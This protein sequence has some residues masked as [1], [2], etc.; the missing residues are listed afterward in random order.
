MSATIIIAAHN[1][2]A[3][4]NKTIESTIDSVANLDYNIV[5][6][7]DASSDDSIDLALQHFPWLEVARH[8]QRQGTSPTEA[9]GARKASGDVLVFLDG[10]TKPEGDA[11][12]V[13]N[14]QLWTNNLNQLGH[15][16]GMDLEMF[17]TQWKDVDELQVAKVGRMTFY[18]SPALIGCAF[19]VSRLLY[20]RLWG[21]DAHMR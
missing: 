17:D 6:A 16:Y 14:T 3:L 11:I 5:V 15:G 21:F 20:D 12:A 2:D 13:L 19:A 8:A 10:H 7:D 4:L 9:L 18:E 1:E